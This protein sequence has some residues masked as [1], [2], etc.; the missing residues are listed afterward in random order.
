MALFKTSNLRQIKTTKEEL[1]FPSGLLFY[2][3][4]RRLD[5]TNCTI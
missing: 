5:L 2:I 1:N 4:Q 3:L